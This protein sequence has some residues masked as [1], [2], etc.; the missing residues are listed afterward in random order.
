M[1]FVSGSIF[2]VF[3]CLGLLATLTNVMSIC[4]HGSDTN[5]LDF[6]HW[7]YFIIFYGIQTYFLWLVL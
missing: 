3:S 7:I 2:F 1:L 6:N 5:Y 4:F